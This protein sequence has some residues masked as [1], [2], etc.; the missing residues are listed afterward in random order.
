MTHGAYVCL[1][2]PAAIPELGLRNEFE[3]G[4]G[5]GTYALL[6]RVGASPADLD[7]DPL[8]R[9]KAIVHVAA[10]PERVDAFCA[11]FPDARIL[12][13]ALPQL[14][15]TGGRMFEYAYA[16]RVEQRP[17][18]EM[19]NAFL[20]P[21]RKTPEWWAKDWMERHTYFLPRYQK[22][23]MVAEGHAL[24]ARDGI[25]AMLR[26]TY[27]SEGDYDFVTYFECADDGVPTFHAV[28]DALRD[29]ARNPEWEYVRE[30]PTW[31]GRRVA[32]AEELF[33]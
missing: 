19:P 33:A 26:R 14:Q 23:K 27:A 7:D 17:G 1:D 30:G 5:D 9:A 4:D 21:L 3:P 22:G 15:W 11:A 12:R 8:L 6:R 10:E 31:Q 18:A 25:A 32:T 2:E 20:L 28:C 16:H 29:V 13:G 24:A